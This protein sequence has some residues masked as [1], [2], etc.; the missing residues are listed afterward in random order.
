MPYTEIDWVAYMQEVGG[1]IS[2]ERD[3]SLLKGNTGPLVYPAGHPKPET[4]NPDA[5]LLSGRPGLQNLG[6]PLPRDSDFIPGFDMSEMDSPSLE[7]A[8]QRFWYQI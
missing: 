1:V 2:G 5:L 3:Y 8:K 6:K 4:R 7:I